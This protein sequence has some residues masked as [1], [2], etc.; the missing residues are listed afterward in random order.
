MENNKE[1]SSVRAR[2]ELLGERFSRVG[3]RG[4]IKV[5]LMDRRIVQA[6][7]IRLQRTQVEGKP[8]QQNE[9]LNLVERKLV[10][11]TILWS[12]ESTELADN[13]VKLRSHHLRIQARKT[14]D[15]FTPRVDEK[16]MTDGEK[17]KIIETIAKPFV[18]C[19]SIE[20]G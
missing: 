13:S 15:S 6:T 1:A 14:F 16:K 11:R 3:T 5:Y 19:H 2:W 7:M 12:I 17:S 4:G 9:D 18:R 20:I 10:K 8:W